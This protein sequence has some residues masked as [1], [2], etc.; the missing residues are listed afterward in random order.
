MPRIFCSI[1]TAALAGGVALAAAPTTAATITIPKTAKILYSQNSND[2]G[3]FIESQN[4]T[5]GSNASDD[6]QAADDF[7]VPKGRSWAITGV[8]VSGVFYIDAGP[9]TSETVIFYENRKGKPGKP[10]RKG[11]FA[12]LNGTNNAGNF[13]VTLPGKGVTLKPGT[14]WVSVVANMDF[15][16][17]GQWGWKV[18]SVQHGNPAVWRNPNG[19]FGVC[20]SWDTL[21]DCGATGPDVMF[22]LR[23]TSKR[24]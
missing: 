17:Q 12:D 18:N 5:S 6:N 14:Y 4:F 15:P 22:D 19:G 8:D 24:K 21:A 7:V 9:A 16:V 3:T 10:V 1:F 20:T 2:S 13:A 11:I 23:G